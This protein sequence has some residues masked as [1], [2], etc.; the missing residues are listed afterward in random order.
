LRPFGKTDGSAAEA[1]HLIAPWTSSLE[2]TAGPSSS[3][4]KVER[5]EQVSS[6]DKSSGVGLRPIEEERKYGISTSEKV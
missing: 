6:T 4:S 2:E 3:K 1:Q 5:A